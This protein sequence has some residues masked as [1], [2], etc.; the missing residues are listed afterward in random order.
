MI[1]AASDAGRASVAVAGARGSG[2]TYRAPHA[3]QTTGC[4]ASASQNEAEAA[5]KAG[6]CK[7][8][9]VPVTVKGRKGDTVV[10]SDE[11][12]RDGATYEAVAGLRPSFVV[13]GRRRE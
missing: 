2:A 10:D 4:P 1:R 3:R 11:Y 9:I 6:R 7:D 13:R 8:E 12:I 5:R